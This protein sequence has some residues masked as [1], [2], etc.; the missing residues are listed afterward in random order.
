MCHDKRIKYYYCTLASIYVTSNRE[1]INIGTDCTKITRCSILDENLSN[2][3][4]GRE[5]EKVVRHIQ[6]FF[7]SSVRSNYEKKYYSWCRPMNYNERHCSC[8]LHDRDVDSLFSVL[9]KTGA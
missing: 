5:R 9:Y 8:P 3:K 2:R 1:E 7:L 6:F 4:R